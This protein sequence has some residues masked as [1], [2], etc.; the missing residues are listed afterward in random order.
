MILDTNNEKYKGLYF[1]FTEPQDGF[2]LQLQL[3]GAYMPQFPAFVQEAYGMTRNSLQGNREAKD[4]SLDQYRQNYC[5][6][7]FRLNLP[8]SE[9][10]RM[11]C[12]LDTRSVNL[13]GVVNTTPGAG[14]GAI[15]SNLVIFTE[16]TET[17]RVGPGRS[18]ELIA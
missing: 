5:I 12:G 13:Q 16:Q 14:G 1:N 7:C 8:D 9:Y 4:V 2:R 6:Q 18:I 3:N 15:S 10:S 17:M 11:I